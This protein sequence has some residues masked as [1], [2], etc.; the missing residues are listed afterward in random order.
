MTYSSKDNIWR[1]QRNIHGGLKHLG[2]ADTEIAACVL[3]DKKCIEMLGPQNARSK[4]RR[5][6]R[7]L[8]SLFRWPSFRKPRPDDSR[9]LTSYTFPL[10]LQGLNFDLGVHNDAEIAQLLDG[11]S[12]P[13]KEDIGKPRRN[14]G[15]EEEPAGGW[16]PP[17]PRSSRRR[18]GPE[19]GS[20]DDPTYPGEGSKGARPREPKRLR[21][22]PGK[23]EEINAIVGG[24]LDSD[25]EVGGRRL[26]TRKIET[27]PAADSVPDTA[28]PKK[29]RLRV[30]RRF[31]HDGFPSSEAPLLDGMAAAAALLESGM[32]P[33]GLQGRPGSGVWGIG[34]LVGP[35][36]GPVLL[37][38]PPPPAPPK[39]PPR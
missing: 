4:V 27:E 15:E 13:A 25:D 20:M 17:R 19:D 2:R 10:P 37:D 38:P 36:G 16:A 11:T 34:P 7:V 32:G 23:I 8:C 33:A 21:G 5:H 9:L 14:R 3:H 29:A 26:R 1:V 22:M 35:F 28:P 18:E 6:I 30:P 31:G 12:A 39:Q 24:A